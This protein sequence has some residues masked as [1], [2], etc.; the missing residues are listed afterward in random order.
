[1]METMGISMRL[2]LDVR[3]RLQRQ[4]NGAFTPGAPIDSKDLFAGRI[5]QVQKVLNVVFQKGTHAALFGERGVGKTSLANIIFDTLVWGGLS[6]Y[7]RARTNCTETGTFDEIWRFLFRQFTFEQPEGTTITLDM[8]FPENGP[9]LPENIRETLQLVNYPT[10]II[11]DEFDG[12][13]DRG[14]RK[15][16]AD[17]IKTLSD[18]AVDTTVLVVGVA[19][20]LD[21][22]IGEHPSIERALR[23]VHMQ[24]MS[25]IELL[26][27]IDKGVGKCDGISIDDEPLGRIA[28]Y[29]QG[30]PYY[31]HLLAREAALN[32]VQSDRLVI[33]MEDLQAAI[34]EA[35]DSHLGSNLTLYNKATTAARGIYFKP[36]LLAC[37]LAPKDEKG[38]F[39]AKDIVDPL[40]IIAR[41]EISIEQFAQH[42]RDFSTTRGPILERSGRRYRFIKPMM[43]PYV[44]L[45]GLADGLITESQLSHPSALSTE[46]EQLSLLFDASAPPSEI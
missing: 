45:R 36:V 46:P 11:L 28:D 14:T 15:A 35:V 20:S 5:S 31:T 1:M 22:L 38:Y 9:L 13:T 23:E 32:A 30:L 6:S 19:E 40:G 34:R 21:Q 37:A 29:S 2:D 25:K 7:S 12:V 17:T 24:R 26:E 4:I 43:E 42:L 41:K 3:V 27:I 39:Y 33:K 44:T 16:I 10:L 18:N 8:A